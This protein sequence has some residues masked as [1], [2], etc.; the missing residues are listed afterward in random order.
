MSPRGSAV[1]T[2]VLACGLPS[3][4]SAQAHFQ[5]ARSEDYLFASSVNDVRAL[6]VNPAGLGIV[7]EASLMGKFSL[8]R[9]TAG[10]WRLGQYTL[11][12][13]SRGISLGFRRDRLPTFSNSIIRVGLGLGFPRGAFGAAVSIHRGTTNDRSLDLGLRL[14]P[15]P[16]V[17]LGVVLKNIG[18]PVIRGWNG[19]RC[20]ATT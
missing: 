6:W 12:L 19:A 13:N 15:L 8:E 14:I 9:R 11:G 5:P 3:V 1:L 7:R 18:R 2:L 20:R 4:G 16:R 10:D 17:D